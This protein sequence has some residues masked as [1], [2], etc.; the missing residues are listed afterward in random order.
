MEK[1]IA[2][3][4]DELKKIEG[5]T[6]KAAEKILFDLITN[7]EKLDKIKVIFEEIYN[8][9]KECEKCFYYKY[10]NYCDSCENNIRDTKKICIVSQPQDAKKIIDSEVFDG[11]FHILK[12][13][14]NINKNQVPEKLTLRE[15]FAKINDNDEVILALNST[16]EGEVTSNYIAK[17][18]PNKG[19]KITRL[20]KGIPVG[21]VLD[22][23]DNETLKNA[24]DNRKKM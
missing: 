20:A 7:K 8:D 9:F 17:S 2:E 13:E 6:K 16:F 12:G 4:V 19:V 1:K 15:L 23:I 18:I 5:I 22:Y 3:I 10:N 14:I 24:L 21:G 11:V